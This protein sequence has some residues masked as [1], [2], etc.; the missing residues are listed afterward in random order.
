MAAAADNLA[1]ECARLDSADPVAVG[2]ALLLI[3]PPRSVVDHL[4]ADGTCLYVA[5][6]LLLTFAGYVLDVRR[7][8]KFRSLLL[9][10]LLLL[11]LFLHFCKSMWL[12]IC[13]CGLGRV[14]S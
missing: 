10:L 5:A 3:L 7:R 13:L 9:L 1:A 14:F 6:L 11:F 8:K 2:G 4:D 12:R